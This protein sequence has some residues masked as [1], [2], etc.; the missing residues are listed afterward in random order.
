MLT[1]IIY[2]KFT[3]VNDILYGY[4]G[5]TVSAHLIEKSLTFKSQ[6]VVVHTTKYIKSHQNQSQN[7]YLKHL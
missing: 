4:S 3:F 1:M 6:Y 2:K 7:K 5:M